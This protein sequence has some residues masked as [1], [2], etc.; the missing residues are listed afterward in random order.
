M[1][2]TYEQVSLLV[3]I[4]NTAVDEEFGYYAL[5][6]IIWNTA[7]LITRLLFLIQA[8]AFGLIIL[9]TDQN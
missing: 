5:Y 8:H 3:T 6:I 1:T 7:V 4:F 2:S 9:L